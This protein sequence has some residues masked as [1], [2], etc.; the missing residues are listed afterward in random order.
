MLCKL[1][2]LIFPY[3]KLRRE[4]DELRKWSEQ[5]ISE[6][7]E[8]IM[9][10]RMQMNQMMTLFHEKHEMII[11]DR[12][13][14]N[15]MMALFHEKHEMILSDRE[16]INKMMSLFHEKHEMILKDRE[17]IN[18][19]FT[20]LHEEHEQIN[21][22]MALFHEKHE[23]ILA[24]RREIKYLLRSIILSYYSG[25]TTTEEQEEVL[26]WIRNNTVQMYPYDFYFEYM[27]KNVNIQ[28]D[29]EGWKYV[30]YNEKPLYFPRKFTDEMII[31]YFL[32]LNMEQDQRSPHC[33]FDSDYSFTEDHIFID[34]GAAEG[35]I[36][37][38]YIEAAEKVYLI[39]CEDYWCEALERTFNPYMGKVI[40]INK[41]ASDNDSKDSISLKELILP[42]KC[43]T[44]KLDVEG[45]ERNVLKGL[46]G[47]EIKAGSRI[48][49]C[50]YHNQ[51]DERIISRFFNDNDISFTHTSGY[52]LSDWGGYEEPYLRRGLLRGIITQ[53][54][55]IK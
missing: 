27:N 50:V 21:Q 55:I 15:R 26:Q 51:Q 53:D 42:D 5:L 20:L 23:M 46:R 33:Y 45:N 48:V 41:N 17:Q 44:I 12:E 47:A 1:L 25:K 10:D 28:E 36:A 7:H 18:N 11:E 54:V 14:I 32:F 8:M 29:S 49:S 37:L 40:I 9:A 16:Q 24:D 35:L 13:Q 3:R 6:K 43:Y 19:I 31:R 38:K 39:E 2:N 30:V 34:V 22:M 4:L 52:L